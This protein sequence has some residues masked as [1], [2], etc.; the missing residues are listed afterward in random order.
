M[1]EVD[2]SRYRDETIVSVNVLYYMPAY[3]S[4]LNEFIWQTV[5]RRPRYPRVEEFLDFWR[6]E[7]EGII[8]EVHVYDIGYKSDRLRVV[9]HLSVIGGERHRP[10][11]NADRRLVKSQPSQN[12][13]KGV[14]DQIMKGPAVFQPTKPPT[15]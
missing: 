1:F 5:D 12:L 8:R 4:L 11:M 9:D 6:R 2:L 7:I 10:V 14:A 13:H 3:Q 15:L